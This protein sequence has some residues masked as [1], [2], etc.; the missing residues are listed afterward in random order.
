[1]MQALTQKMR[2]RY[3]YKLIDVHRRIFTILELTGQQKI[4]DVDEGN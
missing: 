2:M 3:Q 1:M 4:R